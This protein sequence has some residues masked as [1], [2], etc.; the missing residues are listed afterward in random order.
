MKAIVQEGY[1]SADVF[2]LREIE[3]PV[4]ADDGVLVKVGAASVNALDWHLRQ[5][6]PH[7]IGRLLRSPRIPVRGVDLAGRVEAVG[8]NVTRFKPGDEVF[9]AGR[10]SFAEYVTT[11]EA[12]LAPK[13]RNLTFE[14]A[15]ALP[16]AGLSALQ[17][18]R[19]AARLRPGQRV[20][21][22][23]AGGG[24]GTFA[25]LVAKAL[26]AHVTAVTST[27]NLDLVRSI[28]ADEAIDYTKEDF[29]RSGKSYDVVFDIGADRSFA[30]CRRV[31]TSNGT[32]VLAGASKEVFRVL[33]RLVAAPVL[34]RLGSRRFAVL[35]ARVTHEDLVV[36]KDLAEA[37]KLTPVIDRTY[38]LGEAADAIRYVGTRQARGKVVVT[39]AG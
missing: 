5:R 38:P 31:M 2:K 1:G 36:L 33:S 4:V 34:S 13:P 15:A 3:R 14:Q 30:E 12:R 18:L 27:K 9:G 25:V 26:G 22:H 6:L 17:G 8:R 29:T 16:V 11:T 10:G 37:G 39:V 7:L 21:I 24:L 35:M 20:L 28:G 32:L 19:D 23:G